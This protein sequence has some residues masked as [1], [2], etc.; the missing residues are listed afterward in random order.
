MAD[1]L[2]C[3]G[4]INLK[5]T[6]VGGWGTLSVVPPHISEAERMKGHCVEPAVCRNFGV[7]L[8]RGDEN[9]VQWTGSQCSTVEWFWEV[10]D[11]FQRDMDGKSCVEASVL[12]KVSTWF[13]STRSLTTGFILPHTSTHYLASD[14]AA[15]WKQLCNVL[16]QAPV[17]GG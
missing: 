16:F 12:C 7:C 15:C 11:P 17:C 2:I 13:F 9:V 8:T 14:R 6:G 5:E 10:E 3:V 1:Q 4:L